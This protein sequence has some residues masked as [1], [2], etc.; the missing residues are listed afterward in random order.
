M[1]IS[2]S[3]WGPSCFVFLLFLL[4]WS[5]VESLC[6]VSTWCTAKWLTIYTHT[7][8]CMQSFSLWFITGP[9]AEFPVL[10][11]GSSVFIYVIY[12][13][14]HQL[15]PDSS[16]ILALPALS[17][18]VT[19]SLFSMLVSLFLFHRWVRLQPFCRS[20]TQVVP[21]DVCLYLTD[22]TYVTTSRS[23]YVPA[24]GIISCFLWLRNIYGPHLLYPVLCWWTFRLLPCL[25][26]CK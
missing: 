24:R 1:T 25:G 8:I 17:L 20:H 26:Y 15:I 11:S 12:S 5:R 18:L 23:I 7:C 3:S 13:S 4:C 19:V 9:W 14:V 21:Y 6:C 10:C 22:F 16:F 2:L